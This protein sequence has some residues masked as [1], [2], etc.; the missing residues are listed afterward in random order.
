MNFDFNEDQKLIGDTLR[1]FLDERYPIEKHIEQFEGSNDVVDL[2]AELGELGVPSMLIEE[3][4]GGQGMTFVDAAL[5]FEELGRAI[6]PVS[7]VESFAGWRPA[8]T[9]RVRA[10]KRNASRGTRIGI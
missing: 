5:V 9:F 1:K 3:S 7:V 8:V 10:A 4:A 6:A 2:W